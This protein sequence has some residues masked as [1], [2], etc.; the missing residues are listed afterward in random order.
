MLKLKN[1]SAIAF[2]FFFIAISLTV[3]N[4]FAQFGKN[5]VQY[6]VFDWKYIQTKHFDIYFNQGG[7]DLAEFTAI[8]AESSLVSLS[9]N[10]DYHISNRVMLDHYCH[11]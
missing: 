1:F 6:K 7:K 5:K 4:A 11:T 2:L 10:L 9:N 3:N 8:V